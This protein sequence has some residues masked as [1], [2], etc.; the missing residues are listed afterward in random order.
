[1]NS[2]APTLAFA[3]VTVNS[4]HMARDKTYTKLM[5]S[6]AWRITRNRHMARYPLCERCNTQGRTTA[7]TVVHHR[8]PIETGRSEAEKERLAYEP[9]NLMSLCGQCHRDIHMELAKGSREEN[10]KRQRQRAESFVNRVT[11]AT[12]GGVFLNRRGVL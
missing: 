7:A 9:G 4:T 3:S 5:S 12:P 6:V 8:I 1:M 11:G 2:P 10:E